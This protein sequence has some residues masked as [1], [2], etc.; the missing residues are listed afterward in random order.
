MR[1]IQ[2][3]PVRENDDD[4][5]RAA[6]KHRSQILGSILNWAHD[7]NASQV[8]IDPALPD[9]IRCL[10]SDGLSVTTELGPTPA[11]HTN[12]LTQFVRDII[13]G[14]PWIRPAKRMI[15]GV[16]KWPYAA[17]FEIRANGEYTSS[18]WRLKMDVEKAIFKKIQLQSDGN[19]VG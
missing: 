19:S 3:F 13:D 12:S 6:W 15:R 11:E 4:N 17:V 10:T 8:E 16:L 9:P 2:L 7:A 14:H 1:T 5:F 18:T